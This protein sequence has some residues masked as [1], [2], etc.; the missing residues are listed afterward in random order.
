MNSWLYGFSKK[1]ACAV[2]LLGLSFPL[3]AAT[4]VEAFSV[5]GLENYRGDHLS[6]YYVSGRPAGLGTSGQELHVNKVLKGP[7]KYKI[8]SDGVVNIK[9][10]NVPR[11]GWTSF[12]FVVFVVHA[13]STHALTNPV[14][15]GGVI[16]REPVRYYDNSFNVDYSRVNKAFEFKAFKTARE[17]SNGGSIDL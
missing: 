13:Q 14:Y 1:M 10:A 9:A 8:S 12:N 17:I 15:R 16:E 7:T 2:V 11:D 4:K 5:R 6:L 3:L